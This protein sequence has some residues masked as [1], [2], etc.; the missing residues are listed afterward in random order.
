MQKVIYSNKGG[1]GIILDPN[2]KEES[3]FGSKQFIINGTTLQQTDTTNL[4]GLFDRPVRYAG[5]LLDD[6]KCMVFYLGHTPELFGFRRYYSC[7]Y[8]ITEKR[9]VNKYTPY[10]ARDFLFVNG[11][12]K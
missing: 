2:E 1:L 9:L 5:N 3:F 8:W 7:F 11:K 6:E 4:F 10:S 12:W